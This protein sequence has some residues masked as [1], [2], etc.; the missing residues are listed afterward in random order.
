MQRIVAIFK[1]DV[2]TL[3]QRLLR[4]LLRIHLYRVRIIYKAGTDLFISDWL[5]RQ[6]YNENKDAEIPSMQ[7]SDNVIQTGTN[8]PECIKVHEL[9]QAIS[10]DQHLQCLKDYIIHDIYMTNTTRHKTIIDI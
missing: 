5:S 6:N 2:A 8:I 9:Q 1:K 10:Q 4:I 3:S 7:L